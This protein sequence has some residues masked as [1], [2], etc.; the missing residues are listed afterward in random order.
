MWSA[1]GAAP[2][3]PSFTLPNPAFCLTMETAGWILVALPIALA[4]YAYI[5]YPALLWLLA[6]RRASAVSPGVALPMVTVVIPAYN[7][8]AQIRGAIEALL[9]QD[10]PSER[11]QIL[12]LSDGSTDGT[13]AIVSEYEP[14]GVEL[15]RMPTRSGKTAAENAAIARIRGEIVVNSDASIRMHPAAIRLLVAQMADRG[16]G[17][18]STRD[19]SVAAGQTV[20]N[21]TEAGYVGYEMRI[22]GL[23]TRAGGIVGA[24]GS[25]YAIRAELHKLPVRADLS[26]DFSAALTAR[27]HGYRA[28]SV[29]DAICYVPRT[30]SLRAEYRRKVRTIR[31]GIETLIFQRHLMNPF[32]YGLF[33]WKLISHKV[34]RWMLPA[35]LIPAA[36]GLAVLAANHLWARAALAF[37]LG[38]AAF[39]ALG[40]I[41]PSARPMPRLLSVVTF[42]AAANLAVVHALWRVAQGGEDRLWEPTRRT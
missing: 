37:G 10:Y 24:S 28:V 26:R 23:E 12:I 27:T 38:G 19:V 4:L 39:A 35:L 1:R 42:A 5:G 2:V 29:D 40:A 18:A 3:A 9:A 22:R 25:G 17:V 34:C 31:R 32:R 30:G 13:D 16:V 36:A 41:W 11:R 8:A 15:L 6:P 33:A 7:E 20:A 14:R 21:V